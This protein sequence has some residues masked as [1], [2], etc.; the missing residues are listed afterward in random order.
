MREILTELHSGVMFNLT[1]PRV[2]DVSI[3][4]IAH[5][6]AHICRFN[7]GT[8]RFFS[9]AEHSLAVRWWIK[10]KG[11]PARDQLVA[12]LHDAHETFIGD[13]TRPVIALWGQQYHETVWKLDTVVGEKFGVRLPAIDMVKLADN[14]MLAIEFHW[15]MPS[16][17]EDRGLVEVDKI[18]KHLYRPRYLA[19]DVAEQEFLDVYNELVTQM[20]KEE[21]KGTTVATYA[22]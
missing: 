15:M 21:R 22:V 3:V 18:E 7:G 2:E 11:L 4:D 19:A 10:A 9:V 16:G 12:L 17:G 13:I 6:L 14:I 1:K 5:H 20:H 8:D